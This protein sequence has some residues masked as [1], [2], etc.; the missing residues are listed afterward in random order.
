MKDWLAVQLQ[1]AVNSPKARVLFKDGT[2]KVFTKAGHVAT[3][4]GGEPKKMPGWRR[5]WAT[6]T[7]RGYLEMHGKCI[8][9]GGWASIA[10]KRGRELWDSHNA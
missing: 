7:N 2:F 1:G 8:A 3:L 9:C 5:A 10:M 6:E 4:Y